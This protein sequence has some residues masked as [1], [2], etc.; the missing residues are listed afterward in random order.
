MNL[1]SPENPFSIRRLNR[2]IV[3]TYSENICGAFIYLTY[4]Y[5]YKKPTLSS[6]LFYMLGMRANQR[7][8]TLGLLEVAWKTTSKYLK[9][10]FKTLDCSCDECW[11]RK[12]TVLRDLWGNQVSLGQKRPFF[13]YKQKDFLS[14][15]WYS[16][17][18]CTNLHVQLDEFQHVLTYTLT[19]TQIRTLNILT[20]AF[21]KKWFLHC[22][23][24]N[25]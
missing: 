20:K 21:L 17:N 6:A 24:N 18:I 11:R 19:I 9:N 3:N 5:T 2:I 23:L 8:V 7:G 13:Q 16:Y 4:T 22:H 12:A 1:P 14:F 25:E 15:Y 10:I